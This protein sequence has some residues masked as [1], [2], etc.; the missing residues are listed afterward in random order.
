VIYVAA[1]LGVIHFVWRVKS[2]LRRPLIF[3]A[4]LAVLLAI[5]AIGAARRRSRPRA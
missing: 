1:V 4:V 5:R 3:A 2:D